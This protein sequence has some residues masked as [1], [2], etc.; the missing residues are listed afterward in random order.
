MQEAGLHHHTYNHTKA[1]SEFCRIQ[2][3]RDHTVHQI[4]ISEV[5]SGHCN[6]IRTTNISYV[7]LHQM[8]KCA[9]QAEY[10]A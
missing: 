8:Q 3:F 5:Y 2:N 9:Q 4:H 10:L 1:Q 6:N 7:R